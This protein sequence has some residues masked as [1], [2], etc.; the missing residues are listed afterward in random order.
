MSIKSPFI[1][2]LYSNILKESTVRINQWLRLKSQISPDLSS[3]LIDLE[4]IRGHSQ[5]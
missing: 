4:V 2:Q 3:Y 1:I 5:R